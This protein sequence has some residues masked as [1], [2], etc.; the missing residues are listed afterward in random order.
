MLQ[1]D[2]FLSG[3]GD[4]WYLRNKKRI[5]NQVNKPLIKKVIFLIK[6]LK[7]KKLKIL[8]VG[9]SNGKLLSL[10]KNK[11]RNYKYEYYGLDPSKKALQELKKKNLI[12][13][14]GTADS[15]P[16]KNKFDFLIYN[17]CLYLCDE[18]HYDKIYNSAKRVLTL[19]GLIV[20]FDFFSRNKKKIIYKYDKR[21]FSHKRDFIKIFTIE[22][23]FKCVY[24]KKYS[25]SEIFGG[26]KKR[27]NDLVAISVLKRK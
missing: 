17:F 11:F 5:N 19:K 8:E 25:Y 18:V 27:A 3:E 6:K 4:N 24:R 26:S 21:I 12:P 7:K 22:K 10:L 2:I 23:K 1:R 13:I 14:L 20:I 16:V 9:S 15:I